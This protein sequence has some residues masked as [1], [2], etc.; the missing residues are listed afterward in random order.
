[1]KT[2]LLTRE[3]NKVKNRIELFG[4][5]R[6]GKSTL[7]NKL[8]EKGEKIIAVNPG[9]T[10]KKV[11][12]ALRFIIKSPIISFYLFYKL[13]T[14]WAKVKMSPYLYMKLFML[15]NS[16]MLA[17]LAKH[18]SLKKQKE[19]IFV[20]ECIVQLLLM[21]FHS[22]SNKEELKK[23]I[24]IL[25]MPGQILLIESDSKTRYSRI[26]NT[27]FPGQQISK[28]YAEAWMKNSEHNYKVI[29]KILLEKYSSTIF[30]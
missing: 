16:Y 20:E 18:E 11:Y 10:L 23:I 24:D 3:E 19:K 4:L 30:K 9:F 15:R 1:M 21:I 26:K 25:P 7:L 2:L 17:A 8:Q 28:K 12:L 5:S 27:R 14:N 29:K 22:K 13:N 6:S